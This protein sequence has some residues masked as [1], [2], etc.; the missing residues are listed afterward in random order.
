MNLKNI[1]DLNAWEFKLRQVSEKLR[2]LDFHTAVGNDELGTDPQ[3]SYFYATSNDREIFHI[4]SNLCKDHIIHPEDSGFVDFG[5]GNGNG[6][7]LRLAS[8]VGFKKIWVL[9]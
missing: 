4:L 6:N 7:I 3:K 5:C 2:G 8:K 9:S 1:F